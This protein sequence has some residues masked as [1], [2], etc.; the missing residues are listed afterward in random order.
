MRK[1]T[2]GFTFFA[3]MCLLLAGTSCRRDMVDQPYSKPLGKSD[4]FRNQMASRP[5]EAHTVA[6]EHLNEDDAYHTGKVGT[7]LVEEFPMPITRELLERG[8]QRYD[9]YCSMCHGRTGLGNGMVVQRG[10]PPP[11][12]YHI[13]RLREAPVGH[14]FDVITHGYGIMYSYADRVET[15]DRWAITAYIR[16]LQLSYNSTLDQVPPDQRV[17]LESAQ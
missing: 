12:S 2:I 1:H 5:I 16:A 6:R 8:Q 4:F 10:F 15:A 7:K 14:Y 11:P 9:I 3:G 13:D 17:K